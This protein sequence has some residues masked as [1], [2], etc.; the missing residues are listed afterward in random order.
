MYCKQTRS[1][2]DE[3]ASQFTG[4]TNLSSAALKLT[5]RGL[6]LRAKNGEQRYEDLVRFSCGALEF[7]AVLRWIAR[8][9]NQSRR[10]VP[11]GPAGAANS[12]ARDDVNHCTRSADR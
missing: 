7:C 6:I 10:V 5:N 3:I 2:S 11:R 9:D 4:C 8:Y 1:N 12:P